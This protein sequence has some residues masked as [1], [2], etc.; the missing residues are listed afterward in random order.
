MDLGKVSTEL[1]SRLRRA[2]EER[3]I[4]VWYD[5]EGIYAVLLDRISIDGS[6]ILVCREGFFRLRKELEPFLEFVD[7]E[8][9]MI[10][11]SH[12]P[13]KVIIY[14]PMDR[15]SCGYALVEAETA[16]CVLE[17]DASVP[18]KNTSLSSLVRTVFSASAPLKADDLAMKAEQGVFSIEEFDKMAE[19]TAA[20][21]PETLSVIFGKQS[22][23]DMLLLFASSEEFDDRITDKKALSDM[24][25]LA[26]ADTG[27]DAS[28]GIDSPAL[29]RTA[30]AKFLLISEILSYMPEDDDRPP[31]LAKL[32]IPGGRMQIDNIRSI[33]SSWRKR[34][35]LKE[36][37]KAAAQEIETSHSLASISF[38]LEML[39]DCD[40]FQFIGEKMYELCLK[41]LLDE[42][43]EEALEIIARGRSRFWTIEDPELTM[44]WGVAEAAATLRKRSKTVLSEL[45]KGAST[46][47]D[48]VLSYV[49]GKEPWMLLDR[50]ARQFESRYARLDYDSELL[51]KLVNYSRADYCKTVHELASVYASVLTGSGTYIPLGAEAHCFIFRDSVRPFLESPRQEEKI[52]YFMVDALRYEMAAELACGFDEG[53]EVSLRPVMGMLPGITQV[54]MAALMPGAESGLSLEKKS[55]A[56]SVLLEGKPLNTRNVRIERLQTSLDIPLS[57]MKLGDAVRLSPK[58]KKEIEASKLVIV[59]SQE[60]DRLGE[61]GADEEETRNYMDDVLGKIHRAVR[62]LARCGITRFIITADHGFHI[63]SRE[64]RGLS[65]NPPGG[66][67]L[68]LH[69]RVWIGRGGREDDAFIRLTA[70][71]IGLGGELELAFPRG[72]AVFTTRGG[73]GLYFHG[74]ISPQE[75]ILPLLS[76]SLS[77]QGSDENGL[78]MK[79]SLSMAKQKITNRIFMVTLNSEPEGLFPEKERKIR[80]EIASGKEEVGAVVAAEYGFDEASK[81]ITVEVGRKNSVTLM[82]SGDEVSEKV[83]INVVDPQSLV[84]LHAVKDIELDL[85]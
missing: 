75:H 33:C 82:I 46:M 26:L 68:L 10:S 34:A 48:I 71:D 56:I 16:G 45:K 51:M 13:P 49:S 1:E 9:K 28:D 38:S 74:G 3:G 80:L 70:K 14:V 47:H 58:R 61:D 32:S 69:P 73:S 64:D 36:S 43:T 31:E 25:L 37:Y 65:V 8:G 29:L 53:S 40:T 78:G 84:V 83:N 52:A 59:T 21:I 67:T 76:V 55:D 62:A 57:V 85:M 35:D 17:P 12:I 22:S 54:G 44:L 66:E 19:E 77:R 42:K 2:V 24:K 5:P 7:E 79:I 60:I 18:E 4:A 41:C 23:V 63:I 15:K 20:V 30:L 11:E 72:L 50:A 81:E 27:F 39:Q 6:R